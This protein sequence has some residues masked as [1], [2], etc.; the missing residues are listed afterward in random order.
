MKLLRLRRNTLCFY[1]A[2]FIIVSIMLLSCAVRKGNGRRQTR[3]NRIGIIAGSERF[4]GGT[5]NTAGRKL[6]HNAARFGLRERHSKRLADLEK[7]KK[8]LT[9][10]DV[11]EGRKVFFGKALCSSCHAVE[12]PGSG[13]GPDLTNIGE[14]RSAYDI[15]EAI[16]YPSASFAREYESAGVVTKATSYTGIIKERLRESILLETGPGSTLRIGRDEIT[17]IEAALTNNLL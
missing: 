5:G 3:S 8:Q 11:A 7:L 1:V 4:C 15:L 9:N 2:S 6:S 14:I 13:F 17:E 12:G 10:G 16:L